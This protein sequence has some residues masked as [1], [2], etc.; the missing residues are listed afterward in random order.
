MFWCVGGF[1][2]CLVGF[3]SS[4]SVGGFLFWEFYNDGSGDFSLCGCGCGFGGF[5]VIGEFYFLTDDD[6]VSIL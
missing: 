3:G 2:F 4:G 5:V 6:G 1:A